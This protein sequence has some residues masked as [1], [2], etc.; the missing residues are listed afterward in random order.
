[1]VCTF[2]EC[3]YSTMVK[4][5]FQIHCRRHTNDRVYKCEDCGFSTVDPSSYTKHRQKKHGYIPYS[6]SGRQNSGQA[7]SKNASTGRR[8]R[9]PG[10]GTIHQ[11]DVI[12]KIAPRLL[13]SVHHLPRT[14]LNAT[15][16]RSTIPSPLLP[17]TTILSPR[18]NVFL[19]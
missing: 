7:A 2:G 16:P 14:L 19:P 1:M 5:D 12:V 3:K 4:V 8:G 15:I 18:T 11:V 10:A 9:P 13:H 17:H 6:Q